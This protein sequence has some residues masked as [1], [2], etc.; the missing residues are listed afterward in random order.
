MTCAACASS[1]ENVLTGVEYVRAASVN[2]PLEKAVIYSDADM[3]DDLVDSCI[4]AIEMAGFEASEIVPSLKVRAK[5]EMLVKRQFYFVVLAFLLT[6]PVFVLTMVVKD[7]GTWNQLDTRL[8]LAMIASLP[9]YLISV[10]IST[11]M[12]GSL[13]SVERR[14]WMSWFISAPRLP[15]SGPAWLLLLLF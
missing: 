7:M 9:V 2:L 6:L 5:N 10:S 8:L 11:K 14:I 4:A 15:C 13:L 3:T 1:V 12:L